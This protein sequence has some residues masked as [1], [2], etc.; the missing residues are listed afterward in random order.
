MLIVSAQIESRVVQDAQSEN[1]VA[2][3]DH[4]LHPDFWQQPYH[5][6]C[7][8]HDNKGS[9][10]QDQACVRGCVLIE[11]LEHLRNQNGGS[12][13]REAKQKI[14]ESGKGESALTEKP[15]V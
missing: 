3:R 15:N 2:H 10:P 8:N 1:E 14:K 5:H 7:K 12:E 4:R 11:A 9:R 6:R 13:K